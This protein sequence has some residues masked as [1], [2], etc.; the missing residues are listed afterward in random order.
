MKSRRT[1]LFIVVALLS[2][3]SSGLAQ[4]QAAPPS[5]KEGD[6][7][8][9]RLAQKGQTV[10]TSER[11]TGIYE[12]VFAQDQVKVYEVNGDQKIAVDVKLD[13]PGA[14][15]L[16]NIGKHEAR[17]SLKFPLS[18]GQKWTYEYETT[19]AGARAPQKRSAE[20]NVIGIEPITT[21]GGSFNAYKLVRTEQWQGGGKKV[22]WIKNVVTYFYSP[23]TRS[24]VKS[25]SLNENSG[26]TSETELIKFTPGN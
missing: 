5:F 13:G 14:G 6:T 1:Y 15:L 20:V 17:P 21:A 4:E 11:F 24:V 7:W 22:V 10:S 9:F 3:I 18:V 2:C 12:L 19:P 23:E 26:A 8:Q 25:T 16:A